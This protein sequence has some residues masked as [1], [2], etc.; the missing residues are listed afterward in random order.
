MTRNSKNRWS[1]SNDLQI[2]CP[3]PIDTARYSVIERVGRDHS[4]SRNQF[5]CWPASVA[6]SVVL[7][8]RKP[9]K[10]ERRFPYVEEVDGKTDGFEPIDTRWRA[11]SGDRRPIG[12]REW[13]T[14]R[15]DVRPFSRL[16]LRSFHSNHW[17]PETHGEK[18]ESPGRRNDSFHPSAKPQ[19]LFLLIP[20]R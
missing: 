8:S 13:K 4:P 10:A 16:R 2:F 12:Y 1:D 20:V 5:S 18:S 14:N 7:T 3:K 11:D 9:L 6:C 17:R 19:C 15:V